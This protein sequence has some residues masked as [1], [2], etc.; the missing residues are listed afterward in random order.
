MAQLLTSREVQAELHLG[1]TT[2]YEMLRSGALPS[3]RIGGAIRVPAADLD[4]WV[5]EHT[6]GGDV[7]LAEAQTAPASMQGGHSSGRPAA[8]S[9]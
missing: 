1:K 8:T 7:K 9:A 5:Q 2:V 6:E 4:R 3:V